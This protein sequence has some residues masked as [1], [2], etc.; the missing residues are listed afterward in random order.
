MHRQIRQRLL[1]ADGIRHV[2]VAFSHEAAE[3]N[4]SGQGKISQIAKSN[5]CWQNKHAL[6]LFPSSLKYILRKAVI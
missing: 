2:Q 4:G 3:I 5:E 1:F 6:E